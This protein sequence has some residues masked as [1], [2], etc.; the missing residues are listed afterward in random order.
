MSCPVSFTHI[1]AECTW[2]CLSNTTQKSFCFTAAGERVWLEDLNADRN[3]RNLEA[4]LPSTL[5][6][7]L[8]RENGISDVELQLKE[9]TRINLNAPMYD[10]FLMADGKR[11][12]VRRDKIPA[13][14]SK[15]MVKNK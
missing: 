11:R 15:D 6:F 3:T 14:V 7:I 8:K 9:N 13:I 4:G 2:T 1:S 10:P 12:I 5:H